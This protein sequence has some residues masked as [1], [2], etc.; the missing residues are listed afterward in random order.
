[1]LP[2]VEL[3][4]NNPMR[5]YYCDGTGARWSVARLVDI[6]KDLPVFTL[7]L[8]GMYLAGEPWGGSTMQD[9]A[10]H[11]RQCLDADLDEP[12]LLDWNGAIADGRHRVIMAVAQGR[13]SIKARRLQYRPDPCQPADVP[14]TD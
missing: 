13:H 12:I 6:A 10:V 1:V 14:T 11:V 2:R 4:D 9:L 8:A 5:H 7:P 3:P